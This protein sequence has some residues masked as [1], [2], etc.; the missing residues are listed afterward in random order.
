MST[1]AL[2][3]STQANVTTL[4]LHRPHKCNALDGPLVQLLREAFFT[5]SRDPETQI[6]VLRGEGEHFCAGADLAWM[7][8]LAG[9]SFEQCQEDA[10]NLASLLYQMYS[11]PKPLI[12]LAHGSTL[13]GGLGLLACA[14]LVLAAE[15]AS[16]CFSEVKLGLVPAVVSP[17]VLAAMGEKA[18]RYYFLTA[19]RFGLAEALRFGLVQKVVPAADLATA[20]RNV[21]QT[22]LGHSPAALV[23]VKHLLSFVSNQEISLELSEKTAESFAKMRVS[24][25]A[26]EGLQ[27]FL[28]KRPPQWEKFP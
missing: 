26:Q 19:E 25:Q 11:F 17:Y 23:E 18:A 24:P 3:V 13:G 14:D 21:S 16:F 4:C 7:Q 15:G 12:A 28:E 5:A 8:H 9:S 1:A 6:V 10:R 22:L 2:Q 20:G 27:A